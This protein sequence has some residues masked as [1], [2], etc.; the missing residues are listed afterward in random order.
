[1]VLVTANPKRS[2]NTIKLTSA[3]RRRKRRIMEQFFNAFNKVTRTE[4]RSWKMDETKNSSGDLTNSHLKTIRTR[5]LVKNKH[6]DRKLGYWHQT[7]KDPQS[8]AP[9][10]RMLK[11][12]ESKRDYD[13]TL[14]M[15]IPKIHPCKQVRPR[16]CQWS[17][18]DMVLFTSHFKFDMVEIIR[19]VVLV[20]LGWALSKLIFF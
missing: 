6:D 10:T 5:L 2:E 3:W 4:N 18:L 13:V 9:K 19:L 15:K 17:W 20:K 16:A 8:N 14:V 12:Y 11:P 1:M 7:F